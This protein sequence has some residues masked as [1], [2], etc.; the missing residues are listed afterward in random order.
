MVF[1]S[2][3]PIISHP[4]VA[5]AAP[6]S[7]PSAAPGACASRPR[8]QLAPQ[9]RSAK[10]SD[11]DAFGAAPG[12]GKVMETREN[13][14]RK[15]QKLR[16]LNELGH[17]LWFSH[18]TWWLSW[19]CK[20]HIVWR[21]SW[22]IHHVSWESCLFLRAKTAKIWV[23][24]LGFT[25]QVVLLQNKNCISTHS[26]PSQ[27]PKLALGGKTSWPFKQTEALSTSLE[28]GTTLEINQCTCFWT[29]YFSDSCCSGS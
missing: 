15:H 9:P 6:R 5:S 18:D 19:T 11:L 20:I 7:S 4:D 29:F 1:Q 26:W 21:V 24:M 3:S 27:K 17:F 2:C 22:E 28:P 13:H 12:S 8:H 23:Q 16:K 14:G 25:T 10:G